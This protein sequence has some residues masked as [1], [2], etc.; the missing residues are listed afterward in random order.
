M[1]HSDKF[2]GKRKKRN[3]HTRIVLSANSSTGGIG[4]G[5]KKDPTK[6]TKKK[7]KTQIIYVLCMCASRVFEF[8]NDEKHTKAH[9]QTH[10]LL[11]ASFSSCLHE[12]LHIAYN[13]M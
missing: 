11:S 6:G 13:K 3:T 4:G 10:F 5:G 9:A 7:R 2:S 8:A 1:L 12:I